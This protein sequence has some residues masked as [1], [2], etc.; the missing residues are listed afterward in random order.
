LGSSLLTT[1]NKPVSIAPGTERSS[2]AQSYK[3]LL[4][5][6]KAIAD[7][8]SAQETVTEKLRDVISL[9]YLHFVAFGVP[10]CC[11]RMSR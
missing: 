11:G 8:D 3:S 2:A 7:C 6:T 9:D 4:Q 5:A 1:G 10:M